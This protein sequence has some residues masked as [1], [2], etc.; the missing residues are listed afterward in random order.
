M[1]YGETDFAEV[2]PSPHLWARAKEAYRSEALRL[3]REF[4]AHAEGRTT[5]P[6]PPQRPAPRPFKVAHASFAPAEYGADYLTLS[7]GDYVEEM[8]APVAPEGWAFGRIV[9]SG[10]QRGQL[11][12][13]PPS[14]VH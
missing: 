2:N 12:W 1:Q 10:G 5:P 13:Y 3:L 14:F 8:D 6:P 11:G 4:V 9:Y 7:E